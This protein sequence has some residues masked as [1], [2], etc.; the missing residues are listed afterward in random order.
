MWGMLIDFA[1]LHILWF[2]LENEKE[3]P[4]NYL[5]FA[6]RRKCPP[7]FTGEKQLVTVTHTHAHTQKYQHQQ[8]AVVSRNRD[9]HI[10]HT[11]SFPCSLHSKLVYSLNPIEV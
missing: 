11:N 10:P 1:N 5:R 2:E 9:A 7:L 4:L 8:V 6:V 3:R